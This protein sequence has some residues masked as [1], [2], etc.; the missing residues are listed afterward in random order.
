MHEGE[1]TLYCMRVKPPCTAWNLT[2]GLLLYS[3]FFQHRERSQKPS[4]LVQ[5]LNGKYTNLSTLEIKPHQNPV[6]VENITVV[7]ENQPGKKLVKM[8]MLSP[9]VK[10]GPFVHGQFTK[11]TSKAHSIKQPKNPEELVRRFIHLVQ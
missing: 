3:G 6:C 10:A 7:T 4:R 9:Y 5:L 11:F 2:I 8:K 1:T